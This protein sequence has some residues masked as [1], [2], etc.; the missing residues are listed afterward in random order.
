MNMPRK[1]ASSRLAKGAGSAEKPENRI[2]RA[3]DRLFYERGFEATGINR[4][5]QEAG[6]HKQSLYLHFES[7][8]DLGRAYVQ[9]R[10]L[11]VLELLKTITRKKDPGKMVTSWVRILKRQARN[12]SFFGCPL[13]NFSAQTLSHGKSFQPQLSSLLDQWIELLT[14]YFRNVPGFEGNTRAERA[15]RQLV[16]IYEGNTQLFLITRD[17]RW[18]DRIA[19]DFKELVLR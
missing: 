18:L 15:A 11:Q 6:A 17:S 8:E 16:M 5:L 3:A 4:V 9:E 10:G 13:A 2:R 14:E 1:A 19:E 12:E 7:K